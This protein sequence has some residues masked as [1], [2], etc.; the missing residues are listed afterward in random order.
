MSE[1]IQLVYASRAGFA[2]V[3][4]GGIEPLFDGPV[5]S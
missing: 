1:I 4:G 3:V 2:P 5:R